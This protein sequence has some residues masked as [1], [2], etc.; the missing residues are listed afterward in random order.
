MIIKKILNNN[1]VI[2]K[3][4]ANKDCIILGRGIAFGK[5]PG[6]EIKSDEVTIYTLDNE[7]DD[8]LQQV[9]QSIPIDY[10]EIANR[11]VAY[12]KRTFNM[13][14][15]NSI[16][17]SLPDH[18]LGAVSRYK[19]GIVLENKLLFEI[20]HAYPNEFKIG[21]MAVKKINSTFKTKLKDDEAA[22][23]AMHFVN[24]Q[25]DEGIDNVGESA[26]LINGIL[27]IVKYHFNI[28]YDEDS[29][30]YSRFVTH[31]KYFCYRM[32]KDSEDDDSANELLPVLREKYPDTD[33]CVDKIADML[34]RNYQY[35]LHDDE[36]M[37]LIMHINR[38]LKE[39]L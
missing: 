39:S 21:Q 12:A 24:A 18:I 17:V 33:K 16:Y 25:A 20:K 31:L 1:A 26:T 11:I 30:S 14:L 6:D 28:I 22:Y 38:I 34:K 3:T 19:E 4:E 37:Y 35:K 9:I 15:S 2:S 36:R 32:K 29:I 10:L 8:K 23:I 5:H 27:S 7:I 13:Q